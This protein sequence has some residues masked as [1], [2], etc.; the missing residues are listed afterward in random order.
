MTDGQGRLVEASWYDTPT[1]DELEKE[2]GR[3][4]RVFCEEKIEET[5]L[6][7]IIWQRE[8]LISPEFQG[9][10]IGSHLKG[11]MNRH[12]QEN[13]N[14]HGSSIV[15]TRMRDDNHGIIKMNKDGGMNRTGIRMKSSSG[16][17]HEYWYRYF[18][19]ETPH[20]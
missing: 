1:L 9:K 15:L 6:E 11:L 5:K 18:I 3:P 4:L 14:N 8:I 20:A 10:D 12:H 7:K 16:S 13:A 17:Y 2:R 19:S